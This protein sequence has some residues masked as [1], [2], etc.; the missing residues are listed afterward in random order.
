MALNK[1]SLKNRINSELQARGFVTEG[2]HAFAGKMA[3]A[4]ATAFIDEVTEN[5]QVQVTS[6]SSAGTYK[7][8]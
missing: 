5:A 3:E 1:E 2:E 7:V 8:T 4:L 6:G